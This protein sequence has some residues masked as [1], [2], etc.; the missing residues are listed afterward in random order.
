MVNIKFF[1]IIF[2]PLLKYGRGEKKPNEM[3]ARKIRPLRPAAAV[4]ESTDTLILALKIWDYDKSINSL[5]ERVN[6][7]S[8]VTSSFSLDAVSFHFF[9]SRSLS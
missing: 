6:R 2:W 4:N 7:I 9:L 8:R 5:K 3:A 1:S